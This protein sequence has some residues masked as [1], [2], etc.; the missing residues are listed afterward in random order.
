MWQG[1]GRWK[2]AHLEQVFR[3]S[4]PSWEK[5][6]KVPV[7]AAASSMLCSLPSIVGLIIVP[8]RVNELVSLELGWW[9]DVVR[10]AIALFA[11]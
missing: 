3:S 6:P 10:R 8:A 11:M 4:R 7:A 2:I 9:N 5:L 1:I